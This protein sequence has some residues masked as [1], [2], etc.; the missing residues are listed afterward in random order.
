MDDKLFDYLVATDTLDEF[1]GYEP[2][3]PNCGNKLQEK[4]DNN[5]LFYHCD[6]CNRTYTKD[7]KNYIDNDR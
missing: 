1:L 7:L 5:Q 3:C 2:K 4:K 6:N